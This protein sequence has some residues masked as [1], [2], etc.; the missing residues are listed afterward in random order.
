[1]YATHAGTRTIARQRWEAQQAA[2]KREQA[3]R[4]AQAQALLVASVKK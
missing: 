3:K 4:N 1:M 2:E